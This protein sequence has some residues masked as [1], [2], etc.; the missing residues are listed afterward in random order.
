MP[1]TEIT[2]QDNAQGLVNQIIQ[3]EQE[4]KNARQVVKGLAEKADVLRAQLL[5]AM[6]AMELKTLK[7]QSGLRVTV[8]QTQKFKVVSPE[9]LI[10]ELKEKKLVNFIQEVP[11]QVIPAYEEVNI[12]LLKTY[13]KTSAWKPEDFKGVEIENSQHITIAK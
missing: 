12:T 2:A 1:N 5:E 10:S 3:I 11:K 6:N 4:E 13:L 7:H 9:L 8:T